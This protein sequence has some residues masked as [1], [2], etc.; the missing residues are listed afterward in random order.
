MLRMRQLRAAFHRTAVMTALASQRNESYFMPN[1]SAGY[2][3]PPTD[4]MAGVF[5]Q[6]IVAGK[7]ARP[8]A[9]QER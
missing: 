4:V 2:F 5:L 9:R 1:V 8:D 3:H 7:T 6:S